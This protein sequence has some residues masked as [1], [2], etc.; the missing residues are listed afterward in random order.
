M[1]RSPWASEEEELAAT[2]ARF[3]ELSSRESALCAAAVSAITARFDDHHLHP[4]TWYIRALNRFILRET[5][6]I[7]FYQRVMRKL[8]LPSRVAQ[9]Q[10]CR[11][12]LASFVTRLLADLSKY[13]LYA[14]CYE[15]FTYVAFLQDDES[16]IAILELDGAQLFGGNGAAMDNVT[17]KVPELLCQHGAGAAAI[18]GSAIGGYVSGVNDIRVTAILSTNGVECDLQLLDPAL[19]PMS[20][21]NVVADNT[22]FNA[23]KLG[24]G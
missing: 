5:D 24:V 2:R 17:R 16:P 19:R 13:K 18:I 22:I 11:P 8:G 20:V 21:S 4:P 10:G 7:D 23:L 3:A 15:G 1:P 9:S 12:H 6:A 14:G